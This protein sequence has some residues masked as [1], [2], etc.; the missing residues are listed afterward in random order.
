MQQ[1]QVFCFAASYGVALVLE[2]LQ[3]FWQRRVQR[4]LRTGF[5]GAGFLAHSI[6]LLVNRP[7]LSSQ[8]GSLLFLA[9]IL[10][11][12]YLYGSL[13]Y[14]RLAWGIF[15]LP[16]VLGLVLLAG[17]FGK[18]DAPGFLTLPEWENGLP[19]ERFW[20]LVHGGFLMLAAVG[21][22]VGFIASVMY[23]VQA[24][25]LKAKVPPRQGLRLL[26]LER[27]EEMNRRAI[28]LS[29]PLLTAGVLVG[30]FMMGQE[31]EPLGDW[32]DPK[33][34]GAI[35]LWVLFALLL[36]LRYGFHLRG[37]RLAL[38]T[39]LAFA[40]LLVTLVSPSHR[41]LPGSP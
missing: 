22:C 13:H 19:W 21:V 35:L 14:R 9:W 20:S 1:I 34:L 18:P 15:V 23:L 41:F 27:L 26:S 17:A 25:K 32:L 24:R 33:V 12:F 36:Y 28:N 3:L 37:R 40:L 31:R 5:A 6:Y 30:A 8:F 39:I 29:F 16:L 10:A 7:A 2:I 11:V 4:Y 38:L